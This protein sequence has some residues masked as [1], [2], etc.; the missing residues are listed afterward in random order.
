VNWVTRSVTYTKNTW[1]PRY[2]S[3]ILKDTEWNSLYPYNQKKYIYYHQG[4]KALYNV[5]ISQKKLFAEFAKHIKNYQFSEIFI[6]MSQ[7]ILKKYYQDLLQQR[8]TKLRDV[9]SKINKTE[10]R[11]N[12]LTDKFLDNDIDKDAYGIKKKQFEDEK[13]SLI[14]EQQEL[15]SWENNILQIIENLCELVKNLSQSYFDWNDEK[16]WKIIRALQCELVINNKKELIIQDNKLFEII[17][18]LNFQYWYSHGEL[19]S[20]LSLEKAA[21]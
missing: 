1:L 8:T 13:D 4:E 16:K 21:S 10:I 11:L 5:N 7:D 20:D 6:E 2:F 15:Q 9:T 17:K 18:S 12:S 14:I 3:W 19:N